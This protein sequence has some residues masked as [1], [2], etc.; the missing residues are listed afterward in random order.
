[1][2]RRHRLFAVQLGTEMGSDLIEHEAEVRCGDKGF[3]PACGGVALLAAPMILLDMVHPR[4]DTAAQRFCR[5]RRKGC[6]DVPRGL[7]TAQR[8]SYG[9]A[10]RARLPGVEHRP[11]RDLNNRAQTSPQPAR[12]SGAG[13][14]ASRP[15]RPHGCW[16]RRG[17]SRRTAARDVTGCLRASPTRR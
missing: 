8:K 6:Q 4:R 17:H 16:R 12:A 11:H 13:T 2:R 3:E 15:G 14:D 10:K 7:I 5:Q 1:M 9:A